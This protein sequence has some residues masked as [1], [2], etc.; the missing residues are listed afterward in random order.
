MGPLVNNYQMKIPLPRVGW[1]LLFSLR[2]AILQRYYASILYDDYD[3][4][5][6][7]REQKQHAFVKNSD[8]VVL[9]FNVKTW[10]LVLYKPM[11]SYL[12]MFTEMTRFQYILFHV[13]HHINDSNVSVTVAS[14][15]S[16]ILFTYE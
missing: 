10:Y 1:Y 6:S 16:E 9:Y 5:L 7:I 14:F 8:A 11:D 13:P 2:P 15:F 4:I 12:C 3:N